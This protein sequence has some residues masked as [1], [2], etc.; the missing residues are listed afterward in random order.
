LRERI[1]RI[2]AEAIVVTGADVTQALEDACASTRPG[3]LGST[4][5]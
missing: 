1:A 2:P 5:S 3:A 4:S